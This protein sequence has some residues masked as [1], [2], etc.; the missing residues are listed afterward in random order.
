MSAAVHRSPNK[1]W[2]CNSIF[3]LWLKLRQMGLKEY[4]WKGSFRG[5]VCWARRASIRDFG[6]S[7]AA[8]VGPVQNIFFLTVHYFTSF[9]HIA[10]QAGQVAVLRRLSL[11]KCLR[12]TQPFARSQW[13]FTRQKYRGPILEAAVGG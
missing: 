6:L 3:K 12:P 11:N 9:V 13:T 8:Q 7:L 1:L 10:Q 4:I 5:W 2:R